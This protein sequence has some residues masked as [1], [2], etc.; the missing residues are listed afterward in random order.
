MK[1]SKNLHTY[2]RKIFASL[3]KDTCIKVKGVIE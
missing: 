2:E 3:T 1:M